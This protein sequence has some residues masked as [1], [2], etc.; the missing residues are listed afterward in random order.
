MRKVQFSKLSKDVRGFLASA[1][2]D[3]GVVVED[4]TGRPQVSVYSFRPRSD[5]DKQRAVVSLQRLREKTGKAMQESG[6]TEEDVVEAILE[7]D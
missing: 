1:L 6:V 4:D 5:E 3:G 7:D 2:D